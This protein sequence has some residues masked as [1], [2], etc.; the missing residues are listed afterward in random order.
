MQLLVWVVSL[1]LAAPAGG[2]TV[3]GI[4]RDAE[5]TTV[6]AGAAVTLS[7]L[8]LMVMTD[9]EG[10]YRFSLVPPGPHHLEVRCL[11]YAPR[12]MHAFVPRSGELEIYLT[13]KPEPVPLPTIEVR[14]RIAIRGTELG[15]STE[16][17]DR[18]I[19]IAAVRN[20]PLL[21]EPDGFAALGGGEVGLE[22]ETPNGIHIRGGAADET[23]YRLDGVPIFNPYHSIGVSSAWNPDVLS[24]L[25]LSSSVPAL[26]EP[27]ALSGVIEG[28]TRTPGDRLRTQGSVSTTQ[29]RLTLDGP[30]GAGASYLVSVRTGLQDM[31]APPGEP[32]FIR[33]GTNDWLAKVEMPA[34]GGV[35]RGLGYANE[36]DL[37][38]TAS[39]ETGPEQ[40]LRRN[41]F[42]WDGRSYGADWRRAFGT[43][44]L[45]VRASEATG[46]AGAAW[47]M[48]TGPIVLDATRRDRALEL[49][50]TRR[51][52]G[53]LTAEVTLE[54]KQ[55]TYS[56]V[57]DS[58]AAPAL[59]LDRDLSIA[60][61]LVRESLPLGRC[62]DA[63]F[64]ASAA[65]AAS[66]WY[67]GPHGRLRWR[68]TEGL[69]LSMSYARTHQFEQSLRNPESIVGNFFPV[70]IAI[71]AGVSGVP[72]ASANLGTIAGTYQPWPGVRLGLSAYERASS[73]LVL[74]A[75]RNGE[76]FSTGAFVVGSAR[77]RGLSADAAVSASRFGLVASYAWQFVRDQHGDSTYV[78]QHAAVHS[79]EAGVIV[80]PDATSSIRLGT[81]ALFG[82]RATMAPD[83]LDWVSYNL[84]NQGAEFGGTPHYGDQ[85]L[86]G[87][88]L[89]T[90][91][92]VDL[93]VRKHWHVPFGGREGAIEVFGNA[94]NLL[95]RR[96][97]L[98]YAR[99]ATNGELIGIELRPSS[100]L[101][102]GLDWHF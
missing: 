68:P 79:L 74:V 50:V 59:W 6:I 87:L 24:R 72:V 37:S 34:L 100:M 96:N 64:G 92:R 8:D 89:P 16:F 2:A 58:L 83:G 85:P 102:V 99:D 22:P 55:T 75:P 101:S 27:H 51:A 78:P 42:E 17:A 62:A 11:G 43:T 45:T 80:F 76:P 91:F 57:S 12:L 13:L 84:G 98:T 82:R 7:D 1:V 30:L 3:S 56:I 38:A 97:V 31:L 94:T 40:P 9:A 26:S 86:G 69:S 21:A 90:Y 70:D 93:G 41:V 33:G 39:S 95:G 46:D 5:S 49:E 10:R 35:L 73:G 15:D 20:H 23:A 25:W 60:T 53:T 71:G 18:E 52:V 48:P 36:N 32:S 44:D 28:A 61:A 81:T 47:N 66:A 77:S 54:R 4:I 29:A 67:F 88:V 65:T 19:S 14:G 63:D